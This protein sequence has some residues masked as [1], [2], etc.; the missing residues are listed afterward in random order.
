MAHSNFQLLTSMLR[1]FDRSTHEDKRVWKWFPNNTYSVSAHYKFLVHGGKVSILVKIIWKLS[2]PEKCKLFNWLYLNRTLLTTEILEKKGMHGPSR[3]QFFYN[4]N[5]S[6]NHTFLHCSYSIKVWKRTLKPCLIRDLPI[7]IES[8]WM[9][10]R[11]KHQFS[12][13]PGA[14]EVMVASTL[15]SL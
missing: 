4:E 1:N 3:C 2:I 7:D 6:L 10:W 12:T 9:E 5:E 11:Q 15:W 13:K 14:L 8:L